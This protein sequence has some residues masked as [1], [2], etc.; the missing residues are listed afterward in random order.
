MMTFADMQVIVANIKYDEPGWEIRLKL[1][2]NRPYLQVY[3]TSGICNVTG[4]RIE[5]S[6]CKWMLSPHMCR[7]EVVRTAYKAIEAA[8]LHEMNEKFTYKGECIFE[9]HFDVEALVELRKDYALDT[10]EHNI[11]EAEKRLTAARK[12]LA[13]AELTKS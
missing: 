13:E 2:D 12:T 10:R 7:S 6:A 4:S 3:C 11:H 9:P 5:W 1:D 8:V